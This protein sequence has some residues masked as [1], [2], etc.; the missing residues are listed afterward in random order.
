MVL[1]AIGWCSIIL[2]LLEVFT[3]RNKLAHS[4]SHINKLEY[5]ATSGHSG[6]YFVVTI[7]YSSTKEVWYSNCST[8]LDTHIILAEFPVVC[9]TAWWI[10]ARLVGLPAS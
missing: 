4:N 6:V 7:V 9:I 1:L 8:Q 3:C 5:C 10:R 2:T